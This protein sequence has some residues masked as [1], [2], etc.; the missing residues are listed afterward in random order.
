M[1]S[2]NQDAPLRDGMEGL[3]V[4]NDE[5]F[6]E[7]ERPETMPK[8]ATIQNQDMPEFKLLLIGDD[9]VGKRT[10]VKSLAEQSAAGPGVEVHS[11]VF[12][13]NRGPIRFNI[14]KM[15]GHEKIGGLFDTFYNHGQ[16]AII[17]FDVTSR[18]TFKNAPNWHCD[19]TRTCED[20]PIV[21]VGNKVDTKDRTVISQMTFARKKELQYYDISAKSSLNSEKPF[22]WVARKLLGDNQLHFVEAPALQ[23]PEFQFD[24]ATKV[25]YEAE[26]AAAREMPLPED[27]DEDL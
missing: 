23:P 11:L 18:I 25:K 22:L 17:M 9:G 19:L 13:T 16:C 24:E 26:L 27:D 2:T 5:L 3:R 8:G 20:I 15:A 21:L 12:Y 7:N 14:W 4:K 1:H 10:L 6:G